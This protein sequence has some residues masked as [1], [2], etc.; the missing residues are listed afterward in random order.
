MLMSQ[1]DDGPSR[2]RIS[3]KVTNPTQCRHQSCRL[4]AGPWSKPVVWE[5]FFC[6]CAVCITS[7]RDEDK[8]SR[9]KLK[10][11]NDAAAWKCSA[12]SCRSSSIIAILV[13]AGISPL[14]AILACAIASVPVTLVARVA[15]THISAAPLI[16]TTASFASSSAVSV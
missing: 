14:C 13:V 12:A 4:L 15:T 1:R 5:K 9:T 8:T 3:L 11:A 6:A 16:V 2:F 10:I 7:A